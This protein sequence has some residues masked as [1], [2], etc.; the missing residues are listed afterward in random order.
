MELGVVNKVQYLGD[1]QFTEVARIGTILAKA[2][3]S[4]NEDALRLRPEAS[5]IIFF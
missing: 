4:D 2:T 1:T 5:P 3:A